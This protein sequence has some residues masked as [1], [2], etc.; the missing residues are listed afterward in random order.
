MVPSITLTIWAPRYEQTRFIH[1][2]GR[3]EDLQIGSWLTLG[4]GFSNRHLGSDQNY[5]SYQIQLSPRLKLL[6]GSYTFITLFLNTRHR[7]NQFTNR[8]TMLELRG[9]LRFK[10]IHSLAFRL[11][12]DA[13]GRQEDSTQLLLGVNHGL[14]GYPPRRFDGSHRLL[15]NLEARPILYRHPLFVLAGALFVD[16]GKIWTPGISRA[17]LKLG[18]GAGPRIGLPRIYNT[19]ILRADLAYGVG[20]RLW[21]VF[22][23][24]GHYF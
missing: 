10:K 9:Y 1:A 23:G 7:G 21:Q 11:R 14:R 19:P 8:F 22:F 6:N 15:F 18:V 5:R 16:G 17:A 3:T 4:I 20:D 13:L 24:L 12:G 2:L